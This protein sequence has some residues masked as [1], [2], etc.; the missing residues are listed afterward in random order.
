MLDALP[1]NLATDDRA[2]GA[3]ARLGFAALLK[4]APPANRLRA[5]HRRDPGDL[6]AR[7]LLG[8]RL[9]IAGDA[10]GGLQQF[11]DML[12]PIAPGRR[13]GKEG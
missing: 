2:S 10:E 8:V 9:M 5:A 11:L 12:R 7:D 1:A 4:D 3:C 13:P 6:R